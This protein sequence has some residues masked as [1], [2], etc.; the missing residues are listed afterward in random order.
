MPLLADAIV[1][2]RG[3]LDIGANQVAVQAFHGVGNDN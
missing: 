2:D 1:F 3:E